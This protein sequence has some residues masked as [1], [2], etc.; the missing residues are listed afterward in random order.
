MALDYMLTFPCEVRKNVPEEKLVVLVGY[1]NLAE[2]AVAQI[3]QSHPAMPMEQILGVEVHVRQKRPDGTAEQMP[4]RIGQLVEQAQALRP[5]TQ[6]CGPCRANIADRPFGCMAKINYPIKKESE[7]WLLSRLP[8][9]IHDPNL[10]L[11]FRLLSGLKIDGQPVDVMRARLCE[12]QQPLVRRWGNPPGQQQI[13][14]SQII[15]MLGF[16]GNIRPQQ[17][18][19]FTK[20]LGLLSVL[21]DPHPPSA[22]IEQFKTLMCAI[23]MAGRLNAGISV[24]S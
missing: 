22:N 11:L 14:S 24:D 7:E 12:L 9:D 2:F 1:M 15:H 5:Y 16:G 6:H 21:T 19:L 10:A 13:T 3:R 20:L 4:M 17:A 18:A 23:V 8:D